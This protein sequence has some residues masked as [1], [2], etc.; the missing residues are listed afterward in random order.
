MGAARPARKRPFMHSRAGSKAIFT[1][2]ALSGRIAGSGIAD[3][4][5][6]RY[7]RPRT[8]LCRI[9]RR[10]A[11]KRRVQSCNLPLSSNGNQSRNQRIGCVPDTPRAEI[12]QQVYPTRRCSTFVIARLLRQRSMRTT[13]VTSDRHAKILCF[14]ICS[15]VCG[16]AAKQSRL[17]M[18]RDAR[19]V[20]RCNV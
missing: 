5:S 4:R 3:R 17:D 20:S 2:S 16:A 19:Y 10:N 13:S 15:S 14:L 1:L 7:E 12:G 18:S 11:L 9:F 6:S 8:L